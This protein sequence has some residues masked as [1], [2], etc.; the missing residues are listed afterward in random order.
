MESH[1]VMTLYIKGH[2]VSIAVE[3]W[4]RMPA[5][6]RPTHIDCLYA[7]RG[8]CM[9][10]Y[11]LIVSA[12]LLAPDTPVAP[13]VRS[14]H[15]YIRAMIDEAQVRSATFRH[16]VR[17]IEATDGIVYVEEGDC[18]HGVR[19]CLPLVITSTGDFRILR[20]LIDARQKDWDVMAE[21]GHELQHALEVFSERNVRANEQIFFLFYKTYT[22]Q[23]QIR[24]G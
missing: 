18:R 1:G 15:A 22:Y 13:R 14:S 10:A 3:P 5:P 11:L 8:G 23:R 19:A 6:L 17:A 20:V 9:T 24:D 4:N 2:R 16:L 21:I 7:E 12:L